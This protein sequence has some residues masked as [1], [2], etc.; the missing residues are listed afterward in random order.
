MCNPCATTTPGTYRAVG[1]QASR[2][3]W[4]LSESIHTHKQCLTCTGMN[5]ERRNK[6]MG[7]VSGR[8]VSYIP[9]LF[10]FAHHYPQSCANPG[11]LFLSLR[12]SRFRAVL[13]GTKG[14]PVLYFE[15]DFV[16]AAHACIY[17]HHCLASHPT[18]LILRGNP[19]PLS[20]S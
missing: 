19:G 9:P 11:P 13:E 1:Y 7:Y 4:I 3:C 20:L 15:L 2:F 10:S 6:T 5:Y 14:C 12:R 16:K 8:H 18:T 17:H